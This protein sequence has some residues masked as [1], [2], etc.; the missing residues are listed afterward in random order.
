MAYQIIDQWP[1]PKFMS[2]SLNGVWSLANIQLTTTTS[3]PAWR[4]DSQN[5]LTRQSSPFY[6]AQPWGNLISLTSKISF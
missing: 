1:R 2:I 5:E 3:Y 6:A 4:T